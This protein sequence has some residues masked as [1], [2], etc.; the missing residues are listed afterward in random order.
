MANPA[1]ER[2]KTRRN[3]SS[4]EGVRRDTRPQKAFRAGT[5]PLL[6]RSFRVV[7]ATAVLALF[8]DLGT[9][10]LPSHTATTLLNRPWLTW[11]PEWPFF[12][13]QVC[14]VPGHWA[15]HRTDPLGAGLTWL[16]R[17]ILS[18][19]LSWVSFIL[20]TPPDVSSSTP[21][22]FYSTPRPTPL[23]VAP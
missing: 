19:F 17:L 3:T 16:Y 13:V 10:T 1:M 11:G 21:S 4:N 2:A 6:W 15:K 5:S 8:G 22:G 20:P 14:K 12:S 9:L 7:G 18:R 23:E